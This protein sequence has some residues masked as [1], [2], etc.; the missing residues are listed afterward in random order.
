MRSR[1]NS[2]TVLS[3]LAALS[4]SQVVPAAFAREADGA[5][6]ATPARSEKIP[7]VRVFDV[8]AALPRQNP[9][10]VAAARASQA[11]AP[12]AQAPKK[13]STLKWILIGAGAGVGVGAIILAK[14]P[15]TPV[16]TVG[17]PIVERP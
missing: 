9:A 5:E 10:L 3:I 15:S 6:S 4:F 17:M 1:S 11:A 12:Q 7:L 13:R 16:I 2:I 8:A 14:K